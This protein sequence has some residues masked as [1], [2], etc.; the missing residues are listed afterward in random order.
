MASRYA[1]TDAYMRMRER[2]DDT[3][4]SEHQARVRG[5][6]PYHAHAVC[7]HG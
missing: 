2:T 6:V 4:A 7:M 1:H 3:N 5:C